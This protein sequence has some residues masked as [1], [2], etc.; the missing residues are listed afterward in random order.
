MGMGMGMGMGLLLR[1][2]GSYTSK[3]LGTNPVQMLVLDETSG[4]TA[5]DSSG[6]GHNGEYSEDVSNWTPRESILGVSL[7]RNDGTRYVDLLPAG[8]SFSSSFDGAECSVLFV[9]RRTDTWSDDSLYAVRFFVDA[10]NVLQIIALA[11]GVIRCNREGGGTSDSIDHDT[12]TGTDEWV[13]A[14]VTVS[15][16]NDRLRFF[17][18]AQQVGNTKSGLGAWAGSLA[19]AVIHAQTSAGI[20]ALIGLGGLY[21]YWDRELSDADRATVL[22]SGGGLY[23]PTA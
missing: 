21:A 1:R 19:Q 11:T 4:T 7:P 12:G 5:A 8:G 15:E 14:L 20:N 9:F 22:S 13:R 17:I 3:V 10:S 18:G 2:R 16:T 6:N 23:D